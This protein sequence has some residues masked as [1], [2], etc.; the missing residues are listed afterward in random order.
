MQLALLTVLLPT[1]LAFGSEVPYDP[2]R[3]R[4]YLVAR[5]PDRDLRYFAQASNDSG[6]VQNTG[7][8]GKRLALVAS[9]RPFFS[10]PTGALLK[11]VAFP[12]WG[13][14]SNGKKQK[15]AIYFAVE[16]YFVTKALIW[17]HRARESGIEYDAYDHRRDRRNFFTWLTGITIFVSMFDAYADSYLLDLERTR[18]LDDEFW[19]G[20]AHSD[21]DLDALGHNRPLRLSVGLSF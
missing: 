15:A 2:S 6:D 17:R 8:T 1:C 16:T 18:Q 13:Q 19:G 20:K 3:I 12:G 5:S 14:W 7:V 10:S 9:H 21:L 11:S 4:S